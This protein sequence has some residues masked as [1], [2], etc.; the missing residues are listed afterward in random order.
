MET[1]SNIANENVNN[2]D[3]P[4]FTAIPV[5]SVTPDTAKNNVLNLNA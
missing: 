4:D 3:V 5:P 1:A 2:E